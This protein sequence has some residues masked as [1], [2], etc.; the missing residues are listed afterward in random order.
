[1]LSELQFKQWTPWEVVASETDSDPA[2]TFADPNTLTL[3]VRGRADQT[4]QL[5]TRTNGNWGSWKSLGAPTAGAASAPAIRAW[6]SSLTF[7]GLS[8]AVLGNDGLLYL[9]KCLD[10]AC[11]GITGGS[12]AWSKVPAPPPGTLI[13][14]P[15]T[16]FTNGG[17]LLVTAVGSDNNAW[18]IGT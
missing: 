13:S 8:V 15:A 2:V 16:T 3:A 1:E 14:K 6:G 10:A 4:I 11:S 12:D 5:R 7:A 9:L 18:L 17:I